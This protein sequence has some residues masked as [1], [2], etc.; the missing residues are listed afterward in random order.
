MRRLAEVLVE[1]LVLHQRLRPWLALQRPLALLLLLRDEHHRLCLP[2]L[3]GPCLAEVLRSLQCR[4]TLC[5]DWGGSD[6][7]RQ[8]CWD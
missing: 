1:V 5:L 3:V 4:Q 7:D 8:V 6:F 2:V